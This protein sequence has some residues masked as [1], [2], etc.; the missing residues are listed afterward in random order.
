MAYATASDGVPYLLEKILSA[1]GM[2]AKSTNGIEA[3]LARIAN[4]IEAGVVASGDGSN[5]TYTDTNTGAVY[6]FKMI[7]GVPTYV[8]Q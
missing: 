7:S 2:D 1:L 3:N 4:A 5:I 8:P 6:K